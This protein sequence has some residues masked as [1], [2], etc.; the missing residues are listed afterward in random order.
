MVAVDASFRRRLLSATRLFKTRNVGIGKAQ[1]CFVVPDRLRFFW[2][3]C[4]ARNASEAGT[5]VGGPL[6]PAR[7]KLTARRAH[8]LRLLRVSCKY[9][10][11][12]IRVPHTLRD[13]LCS[14]FGRCFVIYYEGLVDLSGAAPV[15]V[16]V[17]LLGALV[18]FLLQAGGQIFRH[19]YFLVSVDN[20]VQV[21]VLEVGLFYSETVHRL[22]PICELVRR[23]VLARP[24]LLVNG[25]HE[26]KRSRHS[27][28]ES[29]AVLLAPK[30]GNSLLGHD[31]QISAG[32][33]LTG[34]LKLTVSCSFHYA[35]I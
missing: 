31:R 27:V 35:N 24:R 32:G 20:F 19:K 15:W 1:R 14:P 7:L 10:C 3:K 25:F 5:R 4:W 29:L 9:L 23:P 13:R 30:E 12:H 16:S 6:A 21:F 2:L 8:L 33:S 26:A 11:E 17:Q 28:F 22:H 34:V 18:E